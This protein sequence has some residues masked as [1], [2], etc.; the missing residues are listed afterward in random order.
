MITIT[1]AI[2]RL[3][4]VYAA[5]VAAIAST[6]DSD[7]ASAVTV[8]DGTIVIAVLLANDAW[9]GAAGFTVLAAC[10]LPAF[11]LVRALPDAAG[12]R[13]RGTGRCGPERPGGP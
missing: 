7:R 2:G 1:A 4:V 11:W 5:A 13:R 6:D 3:G 10:C 12:R 9:G 8:L